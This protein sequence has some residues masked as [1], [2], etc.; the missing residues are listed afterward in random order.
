VKANL[1]DARAPL[2]SRR[3]DGYPRASAWSADG[4]S[5]AV[6]SS[7]GRVHLF[8]AADGAAERDVEA[9]EGGLIDLA[10]HPSKPLFASSGEDGAVR[11]WAMSGELAAT[12]VEPGRAWAGGLAFKADGGLAAAVGRAVWVFDAEHREVTR[13][14]YPDSTVAALAFS[15][16]GRRLAVAGYGGVRLYWA[17]DG[18][19]AQTLAWQGSMLSLAWD[20]RGKVVA[21]GCQD[22]SLHFW[23]LPQGKDS[24]MSGY[25][26]KPVAISWSHDGK[27]LASSGAPVAT[28]WPFDGK[29]PEGRAPVELAAHEDV[30]TALTFSPGPASLLATGCKGGRVVL[31]APPEAERPVRT[32]AMSDR[33]ER[34]DWALSPALQQLLLAGVDAAGNVTVWPTL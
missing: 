6:G 33:V 29:G 1:L 14:R 22:N 12:L 5:F 24:Q 9:H 28:V 10:F 15:P 19:L 25:P 31:W 2:W 21:C 23:R 7:A 4:R 32:F 3:V 8:A 27:L 18:S 16:D 30:L 20:P 11:L 17:K 13:I 26:L 34:L